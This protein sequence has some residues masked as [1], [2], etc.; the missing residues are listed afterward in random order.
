MPSSIASLF[1]AVLGVCSS[2]LLPNSF[3]GG[4]CTATRSAEVSATRLAESQRGWA[5]QTQPAL[6]NIEPLVGR[7]RAHERESRP[8]R[9]VSTLIPQ[10]TVCPTS[11][12]TC[13]LAETLCP[14]ANTVC[15]VQTTVC[16]PTQCP[17]VTTVCPESATICEFTVCPQSST[18]CPTVPTVC[19]IEATVCAPTT[20]NFV[21]TYC[22]RSYTRCPKCTEVA[23]SVPVRELAPSDRRSQIA[24]VGDAVAALD[25]LV[26][27]TSDP[28]E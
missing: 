4:R 10:A 15:P 6:A 12:T 25:G 5:R 3:D 23:S 13:P 19:P 17:V 14:F 26:P 20:C 9:G 2:A 27:A 28:T 21:I 16:H 11:P 7:S 18:S 24:T 22:P 1:L 8:P